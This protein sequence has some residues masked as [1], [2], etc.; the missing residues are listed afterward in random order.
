MHWQ[1]VLGLRSG[2]AKPNARVLK[3]LTEEQTTGS[4]LVADRSLC[5]LPTVVTGRQRSAMYDSASPCSALYVSR[6]SSNFCS[7]T[8]CLATIHMLQ[9]TTD[10]RNC[11]IS[12]AVSTVGYK[13]QPNFLDRCQ[14]SRIRAMLQL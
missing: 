5:L 12:A 7:R 10:R 11:T 3:C 13:L 1:L 8:H 9:T 14:H 4:P 6:Q 2:P